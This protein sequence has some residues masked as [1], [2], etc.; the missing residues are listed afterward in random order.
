MHDKAYFSP[1]AIRANEDA[2][3]KMFAGQPGDDEAMAC[4]SRIGAELG[5]AFMRSILHE[6]N[7]GTD[8][9]ISHVSLHS[10]IGWMLATSL[11]P[12]GGNEERM[13]ALRHA[14]AN[15]TS[16]AG[17]MLLNGVELEVGPETRGETVGGHG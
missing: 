10:V 11:A 9:G 1:R 12:A 4:K 14:I 5:P 6:V 2:V 3:R 8:S 17:M 7:R 15:I 13:A 16:E